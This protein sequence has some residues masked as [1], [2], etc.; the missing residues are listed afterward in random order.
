MYVIGTAGHVDHGK[1]TLVEALTGINPDRLKEER[2]RQMTIDLGFAWLTLPNGETV[3]VVDVPGHKDFIENM[4]A[5]VGG[6]D[7]ALLVVAADEGVMPQTR[8]HL[9]IVDLL[10]IPSGLIVLTK[11]DLVEAEWLSLVTGEVRAAVSGTVLE[12]AAIVPVSARTGAGLS[13]LKGQL[14]AVLAATTP[15]PDFGRPRL[16]IDRVFSLAGFGTVVTGTLVDGPLS[17]GEAVEILPGPLMARVRGLQS[18]QTK[19]ETGRPASR[20]AINLAAVGLSEIRR[21]M[22]VTRP[23]TLTTTTLLDAQLRHLPQAGRALK[24]NSMVKFFTGAS[25]VMGTVR[26]LDRDELAPGD[27]GWAQLVLSE[28][29]VVVKGDHFILRRP[30]PSETIG[31][32]VVANPHPGR[33]HRRHSTEVLARLETQRSGSPEALLLD[34]LD[35][36]GP[37]PLAE[38]LAETGRDNDDRQE[39]LADMTRGGDLIEVDGQNLVMSH[40]GWAVFESQLLGILAAYH[41][42]HPLRSGMPREELK[43]RLGQ[44]VG[45][46]RWASW[47][48]R[49]FNA[50]LA[51]AA[52]DGVV[53]A[54]GSTVRRTNHQVR[55]TIQEQAQITALLADFERDPY[56]TPAYKEC[57]TR[58]GNEVLAALLEDGRLMQVS[59]EV[60]FLAKTYSGMVEQ[61]RQTLAAKGNITVAEVRDMFNT[62]R[63]YALALME[64]LDQT[65]LTRRVG[66]ERVL[67]V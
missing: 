27:N 53:M 57:A 6:I 29:V 50:L 38:A 5:G 49:V 41:A 15:R 22:V 3:G 35:R 60:L 20:L 36:L 51:K 24:H 14:Q 16:P 66:D 25:E 32:G 59:A 58:L 43:N 9:A 55:F 44:L 28:P 19:I 40:N 10:Q 64:H 47:N 46:Q 54:V 52:A 33:R 37:V 17:V 39:M 30:S 61:I 31:G 12:Q 67:R 45:G 26:L 8:E 11:V 62:S 1:S 56:N 34:A 63:K 2:E 21:G 65:G 23:G 4:L 42:A 48:A 18:H 13:E 7:A